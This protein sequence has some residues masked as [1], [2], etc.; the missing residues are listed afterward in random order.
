MRA[1]RALRFELLLATSTLACALAAA[2]GPSAPP[3]ASPAAVAPSASTTPPGAPPVTEPTPSP[4]A[5]PSVSVEI[6]PSKMIADIKAIGIDLDKPGD[7]SAID[8]PRKRKLMPFFVKALG[9]SGCVGCHVPGDFKASTHN[10]DMASA[11]WT[12]FVRGLRA[13]G[14]GPVFCDSCHQ[15]KQK[16]LARGDKKVLAKFM[17]A[18]YQD[19]L[20]RADKKDHSCETC[21]SDPFEGKVFAKLWGIKP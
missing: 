18:N 17:E 11:M 15:G 16:L 6:A 7:L 3:A 5:P 14:G 20:E 4:G 1:A 9:M 2:C 8:L 13:K 21:H 10:K 19:K 12:H